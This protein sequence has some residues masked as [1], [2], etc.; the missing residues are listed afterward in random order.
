MSEMEDHQWVRELRDP[1]TQA[2]RDIGTGHPG[3]CVPNHGPHQGLAEGQNPGGDRA[4]S[5]SL[6]DWLGWTWPAI[7]GR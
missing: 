1:F 2:E 5:Q 7:P 4:L 3:I 6:S